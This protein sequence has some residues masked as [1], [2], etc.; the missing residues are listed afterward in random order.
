MHI[1]NKRLIA[2]FKKHAH[3]E[4][5]LW[6]KKYMRNQFEFFGIK[7]PLRRKLLSNYIKQHGLPSI[8]EIEQIVWELWEQPQRECQY[9]AIEVLAKTK[10][11]WTKK[12]I[13]LFEKMIL[14]KSWWDSVDAIQ[15]FLIGP[16]FLMYP[17]QTE[18]ITGIWNK[19]E[20]IWL[21]RLSITFQL[22]YKT[23]TNEVLLYKH[24]KNV[25]ASQEFFVQKAIGWAL[26]QYARTNTAFV[27]KLI[28]ST[29]LAPLSVREAIKHL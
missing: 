24:I 28:K 12:R 17:E 5:A 3:P 9:A 21:Q 25:Q 15:G 19:S 8:N 10:K 20:N 6:M 27:K 11:H 2:L 23:K 22:M 13:Q 16:Y 14:K 4:N 1:Y 7:T 29:T 26:R 18:K